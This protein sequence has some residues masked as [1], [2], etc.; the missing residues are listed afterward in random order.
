MYESTR[1]HVCLFSQTST[2]VPAWA[3]SASLSGPNCHR[4]FAPFVTSFIFI[5][6]PPSPHLGHT[7][8]PPL[9]PTP[10]LTKPT[11][12]TSC[13]IFISAVLSLCESFF[14]SFACVSFYAHSFSARSVKLLKRNDFLSTT[15]SFSE[16]LLP[17]SHTQQTLTEGV[18]L[19]S[20]PR[21]LKA[22]LY[23]TWGVLGS[24]SHIMHW[25]IW[26][27]WSGFSITALSWMAF[28]AIRS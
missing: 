2:A 6:L 17:K 5:W 16:Q 18:D 11:V 1:P 15:L 10:S 24:Q 28:K 20:Y 3:F 7:S 21:M 22:H 8:S 4:L 12:T 19:G 27:I 23:L 26:L 25:M 9:S 14:F 13:S